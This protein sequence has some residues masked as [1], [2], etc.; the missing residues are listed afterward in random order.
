MIPNMLLTERATEAPE[1]RERPTLTS[2][3]K[4]PHLLYVLEA[5]SGAK[6]EADQRGLREN[7]LGSWNPMGSGGLPVGT[8]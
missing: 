2:Q 7:W 8:A 5:L 3:P 1:T 4:S 6:Q